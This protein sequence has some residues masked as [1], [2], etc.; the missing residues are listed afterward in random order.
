M[1]GERH[2]NVFEA[3][4]E[5]ER[6]SPSEVQRAVF[7]NGVPIGLFSHSGG[8]GNGAGV[9]GVNGS[10]GNMTFAGGASGSNS[11]IDP[12]LVFFFLSLSVNDESEKR[13]GKLTIF[14]LVIFF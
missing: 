11:G 7:S 6:P 8:A 10:S 14:Y 5:N 2:F 13:N 9:G 3:A 4:P 12:S 1:E